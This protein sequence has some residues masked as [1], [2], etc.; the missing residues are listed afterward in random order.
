MMMSYQEQKRWEQESAAPRAY[1]LAT[2]AGVF[3]DGLTVVFDGESQARQKRYPCNA[4][5]SFAAGQRVRV[6]KIGGSYVVAYPIK[7]GRL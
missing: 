7:G 6:E 1:Q 2:V 4:S 5:A 3:A